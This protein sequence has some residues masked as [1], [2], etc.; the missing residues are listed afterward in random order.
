MFLPAIRIAGEESVVSLALEPLLP[1][2]FLP[3]PLS[4]MTMRQVD[5]EIIT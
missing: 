1:G 4:V 2:H 3:F 5:G